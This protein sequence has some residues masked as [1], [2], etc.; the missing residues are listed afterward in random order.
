M[1]TVYIGHDNTFRKCLYSGSSAVD[2]SS[3][4]KIELTIN[5][6]TYDSTSEPDAFDYTSEAATGHITFKLGAIAS[7][8]TAVRD[9][10][11]ELVVYSADYP[12]GYVWGTIDI[13]VTT[14]A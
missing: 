14:V 8:S 11:C 6:T 13:N 7:L 3:V 12:N 10:V 2:L 1:E 5:G 9:Q 4:T